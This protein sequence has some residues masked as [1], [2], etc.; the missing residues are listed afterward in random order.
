[1]HVEIC[2][3]R[4]WDEEEEEEEEAAWAEKEGGVSVDTP[5]SFVDYIILTE[6]VAPTGNSSRGDEPWENSSS[7]LCFWTQFWI[8]YI[9]TNPQMCVLLLL[10]CLRPFISHD[11]ASRCSPV[12]T[13]GTS[14]AS[15]CRLP[16]VKLS[17]LEE[18]QS[19]TSW[20]PVTLGGQRWEQR[21]AQPCPLRFKGHVAD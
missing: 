5:R 8:N 17:F 1:M 15:C 19:P 2:C 6:N 20:R 18:Y 7:I 21:L 9:C 14:V 13:T 10:R 12:S 16:V 11:A 4:R 3:V